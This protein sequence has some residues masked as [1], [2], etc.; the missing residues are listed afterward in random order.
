MGLVEGCSHPLRWGFPAYRI[1][2][3]GKATMKASSPV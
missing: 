1:T 2:S 3:L